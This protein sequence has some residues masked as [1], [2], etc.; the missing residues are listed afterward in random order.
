MDRDC[1]MKNGRVWPYFLLLERIMNTSFWVSSMYPLYDSL[2]TVI[3]IS[4][5]RMGFSILVR[6]RIRMEV[7]LTLLCKRWFSW[8]N[9]IWMIESWSLGGSCMENKSITIVFLFIRKVVSL[10]VYTV[11]LHLTAEDLE[12][13]TSCCVCCARI[14]AAFALET[15]VYMRFDR[16]SFRA[17]IAEES[18]SLQTESRRVTRTRLPLPWI[19]SQVYENRESSRKRMNKHKHAMRGSVVQLP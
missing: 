3:M 10:V 11:F 17:M 12:P 6:R 7:D 5:H 1:W 2:T 13:L 9:W 18:L 8:W 19:Q 14:V 15:V 16:L 4:L